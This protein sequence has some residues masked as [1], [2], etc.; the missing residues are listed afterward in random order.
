M[1]NLNVVAN[2]VNQVN[3]EKPP[4]RACPR[5]KSENTKFCYYNNYSVSQPRY[6]CKNCRRYWTHG[7]AL[8]N[9]P[10]GGRS[11]KPKCQNIDQSQSSGSEIVSFEIQQVTHQPSLYV[12]DNNTF[13]GSFGSSSLSARNHFRSLIDVNGGMV[14]NVTPIRSFPA[15]NHLDFSGRSFKQNYY[16]VGSDNLNGNPWI[17]QAIGGCFDNHNGYRI[18]K[19][20]HNACTSGSRESVVIN[21]DKKKMRNVIKYPYHLEKYGS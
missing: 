5:C 7:G 13:V 10:I 8:R 4:P 11:Q 1:D 18:N 17:N 16:N 6:S 20:D 9:I 19:V 3:E 21:N 14:A 15:M 12:Q 2:E